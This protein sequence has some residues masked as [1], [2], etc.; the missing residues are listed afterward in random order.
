MNIV[1]AWLF[2]ATLTALLVALLTACAGII[3]WGLTWL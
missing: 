1:K 3:Y 2:I